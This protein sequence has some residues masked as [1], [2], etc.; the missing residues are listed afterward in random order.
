MN[1]DDL[2][3]HYDDFLAFAASSNEM[4][5]NRQRKRRSLCSTYN[6]LSRSS[7]F[8]LPYD[9]SYFLN[10]YC[11]MTLLYAFFDFYEFYCTYTAHCKYHCQLLHYSFF[12][13]FWQMTQHGL[14]FVSC[15]NSVFSSF[16]KCASFCW[17]IPVVAYCVAS[18]GDHVPSS[19]RHDSYYD[20]REKTNGIDGDCVCNYCWH[21]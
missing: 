20:R 8:F 3:Y 10:H 2:M 9:G 19:F 5:M 11:C 14:L 7:S 18:N 1:D 17:Y 15:C 6:V 12:F 21:C 13:Y 16:H 4:T